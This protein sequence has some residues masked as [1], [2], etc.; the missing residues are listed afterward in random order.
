MEKAETNI[1]MLFAALEK[2]FFHLPPPAFLQLVLGPVSE[3]VA[4]HYSAKPTSG[5]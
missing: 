3:V 2:R 4:A 5:G 1:S